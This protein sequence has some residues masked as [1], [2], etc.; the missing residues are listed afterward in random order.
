MYSYGSFEDVVNE[1]KQSGCK[2]ERKNYLKDI[3]D[4]N[5]S[6]YLSK[7]QKALNELANFIKSQE[8]KET[9]D[10]IEFIALAEL[11]YE[12]VREA[13]IAMNEILNKLHKHGI[14]YKP[15]KK[16]FNYKGNKYTKSDFIAYLV[17]CLGG[18]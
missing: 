15:S 2:K 11:R 6:K 12:K 7:E 16:T 9:D 10:I 17:H 18:N 8:E 13:N 1:L 5:I 4:L 3:K 14:N